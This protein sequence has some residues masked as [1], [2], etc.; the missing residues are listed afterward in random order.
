MFR[1][2]DEGLRHVRTNVP[3]DYNEDEVNFTK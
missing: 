3:K 1:I 2:I